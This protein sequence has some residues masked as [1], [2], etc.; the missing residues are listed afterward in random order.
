M[1][2]PL[3]QAE[4]ATAEPMLVYH[5]ES[6]MLT[7]AGTIDGIAVLAPQA[8]STFTRPFGHRGYGLGCKAITAAAAPRVR[9]DMRGGRPRLPESGRLRHGM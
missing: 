9:R 8:G 4:M 2:A 7:G 5:R 3:R 1:E 6:G